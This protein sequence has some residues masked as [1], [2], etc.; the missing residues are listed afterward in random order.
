VQKY[1]KKCHFCQNKHFVLIKH[2]TIPVFIPELA[3]PFQ[4]AFCN[5]RKISGHIA[6][7]GRDEIIKTVNDHL[8]TFPKGEKH[9]EIGFFGGSFTGLPLW[10]QEQFLK[11]AKRYLD[12]GVISGIRLSTRPDYINPEILQ[13]LKKYGVTSIELGAQSFDEGVLLKS[14]R[15]HTAKQTEEASAMI[16]N[17]GFKLGLQMM[18]GLPGDTLDKAL[19]TA[20]RIWKLGAS[21]TRIYPTVV[22]KDTALHHWFKT[23][24]YKP[25][26]LEEAVRWTKHLL[27]VFETNGVKVIRTGLHPSEGLLSGDEL[28]EGPFHPSFKELVLTEMYYDRLITIK[29]AAT[30]KL[31]ITVPAKELNAAIGYKAKNKKML[32]QKF[33]EV[34]FKADKNLQK[35]KMLINLSGSG[36]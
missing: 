23:G 30:D 33:K 18:I 14:H 15:G 36:E 34:I 27:P 32:Q 1:S 28:V 3:C 20:H 26:S 24:K 29:G 25:L 22:I 2:F 21:C 35:G 8:K 16:I 9:I 11:P 4:C 31:T 5:Q 10:E 7:P 19:F 13:L 17:E 12:E 6:V